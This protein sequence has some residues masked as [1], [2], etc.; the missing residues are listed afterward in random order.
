[1]SPAGKSFAPAVAAYV[2]WGLL[3]VYWKALQSVPAAQ[4]VAHRIVWSFVFLAGLTLARKEWR[5]L[6]ASAR[7]RRVLA[8]YALAA[9]ILSLN[10]FTYIWAVN[11]G[12]IVE[13]SLGYL[14]NPL[15]NV[16]LGLVVLREDLRPLQWLAV[17]LAA[18]GVGYLTF[19]HGA[20][21]W[22]ALALASSFGFYG[23]LKKKAP[24]GALHGLTL[25]TAILA[26]P[27]FGCLAA[28]EKGPVEGSTWLPWHRGLLLVGTGVVTAVPL[29]LFAHAARTTRLSTLGLLQ[30][31]SPTCA[32]VLG[33]WVYGEPFPAPR[34]L[35]FSI[36][37]AALLVYWLEAALRLR[38][39]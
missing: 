5:K 13:A 36:I 23:L 39:Y 21:P 14:I 34:A 22:V 10:W 33:V 20:P 7:G 4:L 37:W 38:R 6:Q 18:V 35:G 30:Y 19:Q 25:E 9:A 29:L 2:F 26:L 3:P 31:L 17:A 24:L 12:R 27:A 32:L 8:I 16:I 28:A 11:N 1:M 15:V